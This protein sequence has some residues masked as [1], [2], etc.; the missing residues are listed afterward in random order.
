MSI[1]PTI[2]FS[3]IVTIT[4]GISL[5]LVYPLLWIKML[6]DPIQYTGADFIAFY[7]AGRIADN[8]GADHAYD[9]SLQQK[10]QEQVVMREI[11]PQETFPY[12]HPPFVIPLAQIAAT[13]DYL[14]SFQRW[15]VMMILIFALGIPFLTASTAQYLSRSQNIFFSISLFLFLPIFQSILIGQDNAIIFLGISL[16]I[17]GILQ[18]RDWAAGLGLA[19]A[20]VRP[21]FALFLLLPI[22]SQKRSALKWFILF[23]FVLAVFSLLYADLSGLKGFFQILTV[24]GSGEGYRTN[25]ENMINLIG[26]MRRIFPA[27]SPFF[28]RT[29]G[30]G[31]Y[32]I[33]FL[34]LGIYSYISGNAKILE[35]QISLA[36]IAT[37]FFS[38]HSHG[39]DMILFIIP[40]MAITLTMLER[41]TI[42][43]NHA[44]LI[45]LGIS[46][47]LLFS[48]YSPLLT[49]SIPYVLMLTLLFSIWKN[50]KAT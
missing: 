37:V 46:L 33:A 7:A 38:P 48:Y 49:H 25:E 4:I 3:R 8:E 16:L 42:A 18:K 50:Q 34:F 2:N 32:G 1:K 29:M 44:A 41:K 14:N 43:S 35:N 26:L 10:Y 36:A 9:L 45:P 21:H 24:S 27:L 47:V 11:E 15:A 19:L 5:A 17:W 6:A 39:Q 12:I 40:V 22:L 23:A 20:L 31:C 28:V 13:S 30:W